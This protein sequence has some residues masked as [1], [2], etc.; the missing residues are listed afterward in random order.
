MTQPTRDSDQHRTR[1]PEQL[2][3]RQRLWRRHNDGLNRRLIEGWLAKHKPARVLKTDLYEE[4]VAEGVIAPLARSGAEVVGIDLSPDVVSAIGKTDGSLRVVCGDVSCLPFP[5]ASF[6]AIL[7]TST[8]DH[9]ET[10]EMILSALTELARALRPGGELLLTLDNLD[11]PAVRLRNAMPRTLTEGSGL[12]PYPVGVTCGRRDLRRFLVQAGLEV[13]HM[14]TALH[15]PRAP[16]VAPARLFE[17]GA[18]P[19]QA[20]FL[21]ALSVWELL[22]HL[23]TCGWTGYYIIVRARRPANAAEQ[24]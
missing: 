11:N 21:A 5:R 19:L 6:D 22:G 2:G 12:V 15:C 14:G 10:Q 20:A 13:L 18:P 9:F 16:A 7:S 23:P 24:R 1:R 3:P 8:L 17:R 4:A